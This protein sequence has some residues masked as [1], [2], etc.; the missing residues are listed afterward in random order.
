MSIKHF[1]VAIF[2]LSPALLLAQTPA[3]PANPMEGLQVQGM[4]ALM[5]NMQG[6]QNCM[7]GI[8]QSRLQAIAQQAQ[9][10]QTQVQQLCEANKGAEARKVAL[11]F[12]KQLEKTPELNQMQNCL[13]DL[14]EMMKGHIPG[15]DMAQLQKD[16]EKE[17]ICALVK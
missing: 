7:A 4:Q 1:I 12:A 15:T 6:I 17:D 10:T 3:R 14:P 5:Q 8:D 13:K 11:D 16:Y 9:N 2:C